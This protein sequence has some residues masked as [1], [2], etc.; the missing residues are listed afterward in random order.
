MQIKMSANKDKPKTVLLFHISQSLFKNKRLKRRRLANKIKNK[1]PKKR[2]KPKP[3]SK[4]APINGHPSPSPNLAALFSETIE[5]ESTDDEHKTEDR[6]PPPPCIEDVKTRPSEIETSIILSSDNEDEVA[7]QARIFPMLTSETTVQTAVGN[8]IFEL[9]L[10][11]LKENLQTITKKR[12][13]HRDSKRLSKRLN[14]SNLSVSGDLSISLLS[15][16]EDGGEEHRKDNNLDK[17][18]STMKA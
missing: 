14:K 8:N 7:T 18:S 2:S 11:Q 17:L 10:T 12:K 13:K 9:S 5:I 6:E 16:D 4:S 1:P 15:D 3:K